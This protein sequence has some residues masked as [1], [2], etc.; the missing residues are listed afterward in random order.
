MY[1]SLERDG[2]AVAPTGPDGMYHALAQQTASAG[3]DGLPLFLHAAAGTEPGQGKRRTSSLVGP[4]PP[5]M[6]G[7]EQDRA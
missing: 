7:P 6:Q 5:A 4:A 1:D 2:N 3:H